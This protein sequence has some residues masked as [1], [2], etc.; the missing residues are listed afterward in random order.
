ME[1]KKY[2]IDGSSK[3]SLEQNIRSLFNDQL[4]VIKFNVGSRCEATSEK[5]KSNFI[6]E[7]TVILNR[8]H[9]NFDKINSIKKE[10]KNDSKLLFDKLKIKPVYSSFDK[11]TKEIHYH[12]TRVPDFRSDIEYNKVYTLYRKICDIIDSNNLEKSIIILENMGFEVVKNESE[13]IIDIDEI[14]ISDFLNNY[15]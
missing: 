3:D 9:D 5:N 15:Y 14:H 12:F 6:N 11:I 13:P 4:N 1:T 2:V 8:I 10:I 7:N